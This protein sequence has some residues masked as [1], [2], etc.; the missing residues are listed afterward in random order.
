MNC[1]LHENQRRA[2]KNPPTKDFG[3]SISVKDA[4]ESLRDIHNFTIQLEKLGI[5]KGK[6]LKKDRCQVSG[7]FSIIFTG[8]VIN[9]DTRKDN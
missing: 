2:G 8:E 5:L 1:N 3:I 9:P 4:E 6:S 7:L